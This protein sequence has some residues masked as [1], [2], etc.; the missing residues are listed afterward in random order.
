MK[1]MVSSLRKY[2]RIFLHLQK[3]NTMNKMAYPLSFLALLGTVLL[4][5]LLSILFI[6]V[7]FGYVSSIA[8]WGFYGVLGVV[9]SYMI[10]E[11]VMWVFFSNLNP[12][13]NHIKEGTLDGLLLKPI[14]TQFFVS[15]W[16]GDFEDGV[17]I[18]TGSLLIF[19]AIKNIS[20]FNFLHLI[21][22]LLVLLNGVIIL[23]SFNLFFR[24]FSFWIIESGG[25]WLLMERMSSNS[26]Y[27]VDIYYNKIVRGIFTFVIPLAFVATVPAK[28]LTIERIDNRL[29]FLSFAMAVV[30]FLFS[31]W[32]WKFSLKHYSSASS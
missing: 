8:G 29:L 26:Q 27:P 16:K 11:G 25:L 20:V 1:A 22:F 32:F 12:F 19:L 30:F 3:I 17:R 21:L 18:V 31:R 14:D 7:N 15:F 4:S 2:F 5:M 10:V 28:I 24:C 6:K 13:T 9:G 23:Y